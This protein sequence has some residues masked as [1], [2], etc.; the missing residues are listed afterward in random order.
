MVL[1]WGELVYS[2]RAQL[3]NGMSAGIVNPTLRGDR[4]LMHIDMR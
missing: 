1:R 3:P 4:H 2:L